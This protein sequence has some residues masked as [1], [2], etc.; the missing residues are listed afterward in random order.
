[1]NAFK[2][3]ASSPRTSVAKD[4]SLA[5]ESPVLKAALEEWNRHAAGAIP[6]RSSFTAREVRSFVGHLVIFERAGDDG[7]RI[8]LMGTRVTAVIGEMQGK[9]LDEALPEDTVRRWKIAL[10][11]VLS[12]LRPVRIVS[13]VAFNS[14]DF[15]EAEILLAPL[16]DEHGEAT[17]VFTVATFRSGVA[18][19]GALQNRQNA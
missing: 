16:C 12:A 9:T 18:V 19:K 13:T 2:D 14:L 4:G 7:Y 15:L 8:R 11:H 3:W 6:K 17:M 10:S 1:V 5:F